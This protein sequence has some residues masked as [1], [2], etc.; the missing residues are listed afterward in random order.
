MAKHDNTTLAYSKSKAWYH[1]DKIKDMK[2][3]KPIIPTT[4]QIDPEAFCNDN[5][6]FCAYRKEDGYNNEMTKLLQ[7][8][9]GSKENKAIGRPSIESRIPKE[10]LL[11]LPYQMVDVGIPAIEIT[12]GGEPLLHPNFT[13]FYRTCGDLGLD[14][15][16][17][18][19]GSRLNNDIVNL[20]ASYGQWIRMSMDSSNQRIHKLIHRTPNDD[21]E[22]RIS[23]LKNLIKTRNEMGRKAKPDGTGL[24]IGISFIITPDNFADIDESAKLYASLGVD[25]IRFSWMFDKEGHAGLTNTQIKF[26]QW[27]IPQLQEELDRE[28]FKIF[29][30]SSRIQMYTASNDFKRCDFQRFVVAIGADSGLYPCCIMKYNLKFQYAN[31]KEKKL[32]EIFPSDITEDFMKS[33]DPKSCYPCWLKDRNKSVNDA[34]DSND[35]KPTEKPIHP[36]FI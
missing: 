31:L 17:V 35:Y 7:A 23:N 28:D 6:Q 33:L 21:F 27:L 11:D 22:K 30:E 3:G 13:E 20:V 14:I 9:P 34:V 24:T 15:G 12:G 4:I 26:C 1:E 18:T 16:L 10:I 25:H 2:Q 32:S 36:N 5:C 29:N 8:K 19:N